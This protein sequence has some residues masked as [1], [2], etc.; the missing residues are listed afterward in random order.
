M[1]IEFY[2]PEYLWLLLV[3]IPM[4]FW[5]IFR[6]Y[7]SPASLT[8]SSVRPFMTT[9]GSF[10]R[11][12]AHLAFLLRLLAVALLIIVIARPQSSNKFHSQSTK[13]I[14]IVLALD[15]SGSM[16]AEDLKPNRLE[17]AKNVAN[18]FIAA[19]PNDNI[20]L[21][22][23]AGESFTQCP[24]TTDHAAL[25]NM[26]N[27]VRFDMIKDGTAIG[28]GLATAVNRI[29]DQ[30]GK[31]K[32]IIL[33]TDGSN[34]AGTVPP[35]TAAEIAET[36][37]IRVYTIGV[38]TEGE[39]PYPFKTPVGIKYQNVK[40]DIDEAILTKIADETGGEYF[41]ATD[42]EN[43]RHIYHEIN[44]MEKS[45]MKVKEYSKKEEEYF[46]FLLMAL[47]ALC[48]EV[49]VRHSILRSLP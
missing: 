25:S 27:S 13:G 38:G 1:N 7:G 18:E 49:G 42:T 12:F 19:R 9:S 35:A 5:Y 6:E 17:A 28:S 4:V 20:G 32:V 34:N 10:R 3:L 8:V 31:S 45:K 11:Y 41:R 29:K 24:L 22:V 26:I 46:I 14:N 16:L 30:P 15:V 21:V 40:V 44:L 33:L 47:I 43:L 39:A 36:Y 23:F 48:L 37:G 2:N